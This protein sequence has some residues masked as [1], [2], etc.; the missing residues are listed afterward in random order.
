MKENIPKISVLIITYNQE[1]VLPR[2]IESL[3]SQKDYIYEICISDDCSKDNTWE[4]MQHYKNQHPG[5]FKLNRNHPNIGMFEN[6]EKTWTMPSGDIIYQ[7]SGDDECGSGWFERVIAYI[8]DN[9]IDY[10]NESFCIYGDYKCVYPNGDDFIVKNDA[11]LTG[12]SPFRLSLRLMIGNRSACFSKKICDKF[13]KVSK[14][15][16]YVAESAIDRQLQMYSRQ[17]YYIPFVGNIYYAGIGVNVR[18]SES[19]KKERED[20]ENYAIEIAEKEG[21]EVCKKD[22]VYGQYKV[23]FYDFYSNRSLAG[24]I[25]MMGLYIKSYDTVFGR[26]NFG[27]KRILFAIMRKLPHSKPLHW[28]I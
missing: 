6:I 2:A 16:S 24:F 23:A 14:G 10:K 25:K 7:L 15:R 26:R 3:L 8:Y 11:V 18:F 28:T 9:K 12:I 22:K 20:V 19:E 17:N 4:V 27:L 1:D 21:I 13:K 5:L